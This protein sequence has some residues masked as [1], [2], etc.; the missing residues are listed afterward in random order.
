MD[1]AEVAIC[2][3]CHSPRFLAELRFLEAVQSSCCKRGLH[4][5]PAV[6]LKAGVEL[7]QGRGAAGLSEGRG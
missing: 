6:T 1:A 4:T 3:G 2:L 7:L 5:S